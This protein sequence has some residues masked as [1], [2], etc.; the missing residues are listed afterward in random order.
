MKMIMAV[1]GVRREACA[2]TAKKA[3]D[4]LSPSFHALQFLV[5]SNAVPDHVQ[6]EPV[7]YATGMRYACAACGPAGKTWW[8]VVQARSRTDGTGN[9]VL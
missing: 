3:V 2:S 1:E 8:C 4:R 7:R 5:F 9:F 6:T